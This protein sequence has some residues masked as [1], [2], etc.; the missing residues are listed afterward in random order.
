[1]LHEN[2]EEFIKTFERAAKQKGFLLS[3]IE[4]DY[5]LTLIL[6]QINK[7]SE[8]LVFKGGTCL[9][10][11]YYHYFRLSEDLDFT[12]ILPNNE[13]TRSDRR[14]FIKP[15]KD[16]LNILARNLGLRVDD[17]I[18]SGH[19][20]SKQYIFNILYPSVVRNIDGIINFEIGLRY[21]PIL[22]T[23]IGKI[24]HTFKHPF[25]G[26]P[27]FEGGTIKC[28][29][30][31]ELIAEK[32]RAGSTRINVAPRDFYDLDFVIRNDFN[33][34]EKEVITVFKKKLEEDSVSSD[35]EKY[36]NNLGRSNKEINDMMSRIES[37]LFDVLTLEERGN[38]SLETALKRINDAM[39]TFEKE[40]T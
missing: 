14:I 34:T 30:L 8:H 13:S 38:F 26:E 39:A 35:L 15:I 6:S 29:A 36:R 3:L 19:N 16:G 28:L 18:I 40:K 24:Q 33:L 9:N 21:N 31:N 17:E 1:M 20:E 7:L 11:I 5:Y 2:K 27:L 25:T 23:V 22:P 37:E 32:L 12:M 10:K 4:K